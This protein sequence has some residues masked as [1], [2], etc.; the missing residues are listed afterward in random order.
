MDNTTPLLSIAILTSF[1]LETD[2]N[3]WVKLLPFGQFRA[4]DGRPEDAPS[5]KPPVR[6]LTTKEIEADQELLSKPP[7]RRLTPNSTMIIPCLCF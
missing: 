6:R 2:G 1:E 4:V 5:S 7:V 3:G